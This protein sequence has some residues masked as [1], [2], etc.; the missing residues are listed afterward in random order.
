M[1]A[2]YLGLGR[3]AGVGG[4]VLKYELHSQRLDLNNS[5]S[6][7]KIEWNHIIGRED[8]HCRYN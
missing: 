1:A 5:E 8:P 7:I 3:S 4:G 6:L 2:G